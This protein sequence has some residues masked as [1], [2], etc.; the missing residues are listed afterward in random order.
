M[1]VQD[2]I[3]KKILDKC[4]TYADFKSAMNEI[5]LNPIIKVDEGKGLDS[6]KMTG[7]EVYNL[8]GYIIAHVYLKE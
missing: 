8:M 3:I 2:R 4:K 6:E 5:F 7:Y 1:N